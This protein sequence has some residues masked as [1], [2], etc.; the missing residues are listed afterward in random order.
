MCRLSCGARPSSGWPSVRHHGAGERTKPFGREA[1]RRTA[2][3]LRDEAR[4]IGME[5]KGERTVVMSTKTVKNERHKLTAT[6]LNNIAVGC[7]LIALI[8]PVATGKYGHFLTIEFVYS[9][10]A[11][12]VLAAVLHMIARWQLSLLEE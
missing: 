7:V 3:D 6:F 1:G 10:G 2:A 11:A 5:R 12:W 9:E 4:R 8:G